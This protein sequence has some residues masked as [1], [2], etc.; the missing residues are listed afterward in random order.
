MIREFYN[1]LTTNLV[2]LMFDV[3]VQ[4]EVTEGRVS[5]GL[6]TRT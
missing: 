3:I 5:V 6:P 2:Q 1:L 4:E